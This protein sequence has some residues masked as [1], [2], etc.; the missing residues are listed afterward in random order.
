[1]I[2][3][4]F[5]DMNWL[6]S[7]FRRGKKGAEPSLPQWKNAGN[8][9]ET[10]SKP[11]EAGKPAE[12]KPCRML[13]LTPRQAAEVCLALP[14][15]G[16]DIYL[17]D[18]NK[19]V[20]AVCSSPDVAKALAD[21]MECYSSLNAFEGSKAKAY[22]KFIQDAYYLYVALSNAKIPVNSVETVFVEKAFHQFCAS[23]NEIIA[24]EKLT[25]EDVTGQPAGVN[26]ETQ[27][28][29]DKE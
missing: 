9:A 2:E 24:R 14:W 15:R 5:T 6:K 17:E 20:K 26:S 18:S 1:M 8:A 28:K 4:E 23:L 16:N 19:A 25:F 22:G 7:M 12:R 10:D 11:V 3:K 27:T 21:C 29:K 13:E